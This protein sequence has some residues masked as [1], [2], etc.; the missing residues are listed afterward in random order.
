M[1]RSCLARFNPDRV[2][3]GSGP[4][5]AEARRQSQTWGSQMDLSVDVE[6]G[7]ALSQPPSDRSRASHQGVEAR[8]AVSSPPM[9]A[10]ILQLSSSE[11]LDVV[12]IDAESEDSPPQSHA[13]E[14][15]LD[16]ITRTVERL[17]IEWPEDR[18][19]A[20]SKSKLDERFLPS[21]AQPQC[22]SLP[23]FPDLHTEVW[24]SWGKPVS[25]RVYTAQ[26]SHYSS[27]H[28]YKEHGYGEMPK[29]EETLA[30]YLSP[31][32][33]SSLKAPAL[34]SKPVKVTSSLV[35]KAY[36]AA[37]QTA[38]CLHTMSIMQ[39]YQAELL[40]DSEEGVGISA[41]TVSELR[42][43]TDLSLRA[44]KETAK[45]IGRSM[46]ALVATE[47]HLWLNLSDIKD[48]EKHVLLDAPVSTEGLFGDAVNSAVAKSQEASKQAAALQKLLP[49]RSFYE[50]AEREQPHSSKKSAEHRATQK[51]SVSSRAPPQ[52]SRGHGGRSQTQQSSRAERLT[53][54][55]TVPVSLRCPQGTVLPTLPPP[56]LQGT[57][58]SGEHIS[59]GPPG[60]VVASG[61]PPPLR[62]VLEQSVRLF[63]AGA[64]L[65]GDEPTTQQ[66]EKNT[67][68]VSLRCPQGTGLPTLPPPVFQ[69]AAV[70][71][72]HI[73]QGPAGNV[74]A[75]G[76]P[77]PLRRVLE[78]SVRSFPAGAPLQGDEPTTQQQ[79][80]PET[81]L[82][83]L[84]PLVKSLTAWKL[85]SNVSRWVLQTVGKGGPLSQGPVLGAPCRRKLL[86]TD[87][88]LTGWG[89][90]LRVVHLKPRAGRAEYGFPILCPSSTGILWSFLSGGTFCPKQGAQSFTPARTVEPV[91][92][93]SEGAQLIESGLSTEVAETILQSRA[94][95]TRKLYALK[96]RVF[97][98]LCSDHRLD[99]VNC[100]IGTVLEFL[101]DR[102]TA[103]T[104]EHTRKLIR[105]RVAHEALFTGKRNAA[106][107]GFESFVVEQ[108]LHGKATAA[109]VKKK[110]E[111]L[112]QKYKDLK[113]PQTGR[114]TED[115]ETTAASWK[116]YTAMDEAIGGRPSITPPALVAS[117]GQDVAVASSSSVSP[118][119]SRARKRPNDVMALFR[120]MEEREEE[121]ERKAAE[122]EERLWREM[123]EKEERREQER[124][125]R[126]ERQERE[127]RER[128]ERWHREA[129]EKEERRAR[130]VAERDERFLF[131][132]EILAK[133]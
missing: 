18:Q 77:P 125:E 128:E 60:N 131:V 119:P 81:S 22:R 102:F 24:R 43:A 82:E 4:A 86:T 111:N 52:K 99:P 75:S 66:Q 62:R 68:P 55:F 40:G 98:S 85:L 97:T 130:E 53:P 118:E 9:E 20:R 10:P 19:G 35:H 69:G 48:K 21:R 2:P 13:F 83:R 56:V 33:A 41:D 34:P 132:L 123:E 26:T 79:H 116:W 87:A 101:Q 32:T 110:W 124:R 51:Q 64:P 90:I 100:P 58:V 16:V 115:G 63:P 11:E 112:K 92:L 95:S 59:Q 6:T 126:E 28:N 105:W 127:V 106:I 107:K 46:A 57:A 61:C 120:E 103:G 109:F 122:R 74:V 49:R 45:S 15:L 78:Q 89:A 3:Q 29:V 12:S 44:T 39:A 7:S 121:R 73:S 67:V 65:Q 27:I 1:L 14:E 71:G 80:N 104:D 36:A 31:A 5:A 84:V 113:C 108:D 38:A 70:S 94:P 72:E 8:V 17:S 96:W 23:F 47:R 76:C 117:C 133:K 88:S 42:R 54:L 91:G 25:Y 50:A 114:G 93:A 37:G 129:I 30:S